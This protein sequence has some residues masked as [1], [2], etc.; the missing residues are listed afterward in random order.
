MPARKI[1]RDLIT[2]NEAARQRQVHHRTIRR[3]IAEGKI[4]AYRVGGTAVRISQA[5]LDA[6][7]RPIV[8][9]AG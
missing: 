3:Q 8:T 1:P 7:V 5:D 9:A 4:P 2:I 6:Q